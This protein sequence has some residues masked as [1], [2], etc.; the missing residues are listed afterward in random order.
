MSHPSDQCV[1]DASGNLKP[2]TKI[3][4]YF[5]KDDDPT[6]PTNPRHHCKKAKKN[7][8]K[9][10]QS[11]SQRIR[12]RQIG[13][14]GGSAPQ[15]SKQTGPAKQ[16]HRSLLWCIGNLGGSNTV[17]DLVLDLESKS[18]AL[19]PALKHNKFWID[20][21]MQICAGKTYGFESGIWV[22][23]PAGTQIPDSNPA[24][25]GAQDLLSK[26]STKSF[27][28]FDPPKLPMHRSTISLVE[29]CWAKGMEKTNSG[30]P[31]PAI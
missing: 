6:A 16:K 13:D 27:T 30:D 21:V 9:N 25:F 22:L 3:D 19:K 1:L 31:R 11:V 14:E 18:W 10:K 26:S 5:D 8:K 29:H 24:G 17:K 4:F 28:V 15:A 20:L 12:L 7:R 2:T 23:N